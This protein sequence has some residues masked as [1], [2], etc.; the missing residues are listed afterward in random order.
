MAFTYFFRDIDVLNKAVDMLLQ[1]LP[2]TGTI[3]IWDA[4]CAYGQEPFSL[5]ILLAERM[6]P[7]EFERVRILATDIDV[8]NRFSAFFNS[9]EYSWDDVKRMPEDLFKKYFEPTERECEYRLMEKVR[10]RVRYVRNDLLQFTPPS[11]GFHLVVSKN[12]LMHF[13]PED[14]SRVLNMF[15]SC[16]FN[17]GTL[18]LG[19]LQDYEAADTSSFQQL[20]CL[21]F[22]KI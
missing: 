11:C 18:A 10:S 1:N 9:G 16:L 2:E 19:Q 12:T 22:Q 21:I 13:Q 15:A 7:E 17:D 8:S 4:G 14:R 6:A 20:D 5:A 3:R